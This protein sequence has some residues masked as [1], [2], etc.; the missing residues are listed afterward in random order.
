MTKLPQ[1]PA[2]KV[3]AEARLHADDAWRQSFEGLNEGKSLDLASKGDLTV[4]AKADD[5]ENFLA[6][7]DADRGQVRCG[8]IHELLLRCCGVVL[9]DY[10]RGGSSR[11]IP[12]ADIGVQHICAL[13]SRAFQKL[14]ATRS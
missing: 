13:K 11:S 3:G 2:D 10:P 14:A 1:S 12:L 5:V 4:G 6:N 7:V 8:G 9:A